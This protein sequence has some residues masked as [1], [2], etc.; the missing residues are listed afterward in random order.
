M[1]QPPHEEDMIYNRCTH[2][3]II[4]I[5]T[6]SLIFNNFS[7]K[8]VDSYHPGEVRTRYT[9]EIVALLKNLPLQV[10]IRTIFK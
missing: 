1:L 4:I 2:L 10:R 6:I 5:P 3:S 7:W 9:A 8:Q